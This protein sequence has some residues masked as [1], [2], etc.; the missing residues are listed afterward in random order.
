MLRVFCEI[1]CSLV[2]LHILYVSLPSIT[3]NRPT[4]HIKVNLKVTAGYIKKK[5]YYW[6]YYCSELLILFPQTDCFICGQEDTM[7]R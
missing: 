6:Y 7:G 4:I 5:H 2:S 3:V 1:T